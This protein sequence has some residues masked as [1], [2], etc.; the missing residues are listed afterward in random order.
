MTDWIG[1]ADMT[2]AQFKL[3]LEQMTDRV[4]NFKKH[5]G[6]RKA[7]QSD[8]T[9]LTQQGVRGHDIRLANR[10]RLSMRRKPVKASRKS[11]KPA[12]PRYK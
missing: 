5:E 1:A 11:L 10:N 9:Y 8:R 6:P 2:P 3:C 4:V 7:S 12:P